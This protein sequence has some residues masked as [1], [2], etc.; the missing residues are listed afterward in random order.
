MVLDREARVSTGPRGNPEGPHGVPKD[1]RR[2]WAILIAGCGAAMPAPA[3]VLPAA[4]APDAW[5]PR[6]CVAD[7]PPTLRPIFAPIRDEAAPEVARVACGCAADHGV[8]APG[9]IVV[10]VTLVPGQGR[11]AEAIPR[12]AGGARDSD[13]WVGFGACLAR[14]LGAL[15]LPIH[16]IGSDVLPDPDPTDERV[17]LPIGIELR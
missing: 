1:M 14:E 7:A 12:A 2:A 10:R 5:R 8:Y 6:A 3:P 17:V 9:R 11:V 16:V 4:P 13:D 15:S